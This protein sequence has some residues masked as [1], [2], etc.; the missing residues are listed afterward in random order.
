MDPLIFYG[1]CTVGCVGVSCRTIATLY[2]NWVQGAG[3]LIGPTIGA[4]CWR[5]THRKAMEMIEAREREFYRRIQKYRVDPT[6]QSAT[7]PVPDFYGE[8][9]LSL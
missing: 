5:I 1:L 3:V 8:Q 4:A 2:A 6:A 9:H 7:N